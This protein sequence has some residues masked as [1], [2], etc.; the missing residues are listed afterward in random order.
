M[1]A[2]TK[3]TVP[4][5]LDMKKQGEKIVMVTSYDAAVASIVDE[6]GADIILVGD[7]VG[8]VIQGLANTLSVTMDEMIYHTKMVSRGASR[9]HICG[10]M[11][12]MS[13]QASKEEAVRN[14]GRFIKEA[15]AQSVKL[16][17]NESHLETVYA[18][19]RASIPTVAHIGLRPQSIHMMGGYKV[20]GR[21]EYEAERLLELAL[22][23]QAAG[24]FI[25]LMESVTW[26]LA[27]EITE[28]LRVPTIGIGAGAH[29]DGQVLVINDLVG[30]SAGPLPRFVKKYAEMRDAMTAAVQQFASEVKEGKFPAEENSYS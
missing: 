16:E 19:S 24:A 15:G 30:L 14:A 10:D 12:F 1:R 9:A 23:A 21:G 17:I 11:P 26:E 18:I 20:Q 25:V 3:I 27:R 6:A 5:L 7:S 4:K 2:M 29:C 28:A 13:Y 22:D 8:N